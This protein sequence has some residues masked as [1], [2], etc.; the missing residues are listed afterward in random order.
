MMMKSYYG[1]KLVD[2]WCVI[3]AL[4][5][6]AC[7]LKVR[8]LQSKDPL[9]A[10]LTSAPML[11]PNERKALWDHIVSVESDPSWISE[12]FLDHPS[13]DSISLYDILD[14]LCW[15]MFDGRNQ[16]HLTTQELDDLECFVEDLEYRVSLHLYGI[17]V[18]EDVVNLS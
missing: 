5:F 7:K 10:C 14:F 4:F 15:A 17:A 3:E 1:C 18:E 2:V 12:W 13:I 9:E 8:Y 6:I 16:E 11:D